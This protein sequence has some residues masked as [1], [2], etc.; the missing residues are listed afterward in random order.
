MM[1]LNLLIGLILFWIGAT[2]ISTA[3]DYVAT[4]SHNLHC[5]YDKLKNNCFLT[6]TQKHLVGTGI[7]IMGIAPNG[8]RWIIYN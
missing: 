6:K 5:G 1:Y 8:N 2:L 7:V 3:I 4:I